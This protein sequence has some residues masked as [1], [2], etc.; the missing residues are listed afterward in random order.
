MGS[1]L[2][3]LHKIWIE[4]CAATEDIRGDFGLCSGE[5]GIA[6]GYD[7]RGHPICPPQPERMLAKHIPPS[8]LRAYS[9]PIFMQ[10]PHLTHLGC[11]LL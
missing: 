5:T 7:G 9:L 10:R 6:A 3:E 8:D 1:P 11:M 4:Q 2:S